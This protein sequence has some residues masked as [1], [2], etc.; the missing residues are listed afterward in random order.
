M[1]NPE[2]I[3]LLMS[4]NLSGEA[5]TEECEELM[6]L[7]QEHPELQQQY[8][9]LQQT[10]KTGSIAENK[11]EPGKISRILQLAAVQEAL[12]EEETVETPVIKW[13]KI[14]QWA[15]VGS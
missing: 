5:S 8:I 3:W 10:W 1:N 12:K 14:Y 7:L 13:K 4:R 2:K 6:R 9:I 15:A 11:P